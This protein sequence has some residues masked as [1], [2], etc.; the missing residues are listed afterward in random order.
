MKAFRSLTLSLALMVGAAPLDAQIVPVTEVGEYQIMKEENQQVC[1]AATE[2]LS[3]QKKP[4][5]YTYYAST[6]GQR[7]NVAGYASPI[8]LEAGMITIT[9]SVD[10]TETISR[11]TVTRDGDFLLPFEALEELEAHEAQ[12]K[13]GQVMLIAIGDV[14]TVEVPL[15][16]HRVALEAIA[17]CLATGF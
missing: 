4:M 10:G 13:T 15:D 1:F 2:L 6:Q 14:D 16:A 17:D 9:V 3:A 5:I 11:E 12:I 7:W 8:E